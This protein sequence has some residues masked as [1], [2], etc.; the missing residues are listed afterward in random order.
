[1]KPSILR[2]LSLK[3]D[4][5]ETST[6]KNKFLFKLKIISGQNLTTTGLTGK[7]VKD[8]IDPY[9]QINIYGVP[10]DRYEKK[11]KTVDDN[12]YNPLWNEDFQF[13]INCPELAFVKFT[14]KDEDV[15]SDEFIGEYTVRFENM[16]E[17]NFLT[18]LNLMF[19][20]VVF[21]K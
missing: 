21:I 17:G 3:F 2:D 7:N 9:V 18:K 8:I 5:Y 6:M 13:Q 1:M 4:P 14:V 19:L 12:G 10:A 20:F 16:R 15:T 11:T